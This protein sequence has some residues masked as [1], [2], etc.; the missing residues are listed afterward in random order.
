MNIEYLALNKKT[1]VLTPTLMGEMIYDVVGSSIK[2]LLDP[3]LTASWEKGL[4][5]VADGDIT[6]GEYMDKLNGFVGRRTEYVKQLRNQGALFAQ[7]QAAAT[8][9]QSAESAGRRQTKQQTKGR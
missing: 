1:Q 7:F 4:T 3:A 9:Y 2:A 5:L 6:S 8:N